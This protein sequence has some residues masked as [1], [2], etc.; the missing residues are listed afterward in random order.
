MRILSVTPALVALSASLLFAQGKP[1]SKA[2]ALVWGPAPAAFP[3]GA[4]MAVVSGDP[5]KPAPFVVALRM[6][7]GYKILPHFHPMDEIVEVKSG[8]FLY[9][10][11]NTFDVA[12]AKHMKVGE[13]G[14]IPAAM[15]HYA[16]AKRAT[17]VTVSAMGPFAMTY[18]NAKDDPRNQAAKP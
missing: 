11:G 10:M 8:D 15:H 17:V 9:G 2:P 14:T 12:K 4:Q 16:M 3:T 13:K 18:V 1:A 6:P 7:A 5:G